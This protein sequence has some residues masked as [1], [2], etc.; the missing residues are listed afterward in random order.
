M[1]DLKF[2]AWD[3]SQKYMAYQG[4]QDLE[5]LSSFMFHFGEDI[6]LQSTGFFDKNE[7]EIFE[8][9][10]LSDWNDVD[11]KQVQSFLQ[12]FWCDKDGCWKLDSSFNRDKSSGD[13]L[14][15]ELSSFVYEIS[16]NIYENPDLLQRS[17]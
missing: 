11:G 6:V 10:I 7:K 16:G 1:R 17:F 14:S 8:G 15:E 2:R 13:L 3:K 5:T 12:V 9:D 4:S